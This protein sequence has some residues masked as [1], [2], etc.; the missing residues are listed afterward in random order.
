MVIP[1][2]CAN[3]HKEAELVRM[4]AKKIKYFGGDSV[5]LHPIDDNAYASKS[6]LKISIPKDC[7]IVELHMDAASATARGGHVI[8]NGKFSADKYDSALADKISSI[9][10]GRSKSI[11]KR[12]DLYNCNVAAMKGY[13]YRLVENGFITNSDDVDVFINN[14][15]DIAKAYL[16]SFEIEISEANEE[17]NNC[18]ISNNKDDEN[19]LGKVNVKYK[20][21]TNG[22]WLEEISGFNN[23]DHNGYAGIKGSPIQALAVKVDKGSIKYRVH[24]KNGNWLPWV[25]GYDVNDFNNGYAGNGTSEIDGIQIYYTTPSGYKYQ[26]AWYRAKTVKRSSYL[27]VCCDDGNSVKGYDGWAG[28]FGESIDVVQLF[29]GSSNPF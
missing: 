4:L 17:V 8:I 27:N 14:I 20:V 11:V 10:P 13:G 6:L 29:I 19:D 9:F 12:T 2:A 5:I 7:Q 1:G 28:I 24:I 15:D 21:K 16:E 25:T 26:Q 3:G 18:I 23:N 22:K